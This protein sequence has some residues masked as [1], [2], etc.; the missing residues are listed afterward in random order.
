MATVVAARQ[1]VQA[2]G[3]LAR[4]RAL[5]VLA[6]R[7]DDAVVASVAPVFEELLCVVADFEADE[8]RACLELAEG[9]WPVLRVR[10]PKKE[11]RN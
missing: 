11:C 5:V 1:V 9:P 8:A 7:G 6:D 4:L 10:L 2:I 3:A